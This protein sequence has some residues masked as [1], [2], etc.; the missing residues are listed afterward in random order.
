MHGHGPH[1]WW[2]AA[3]LVAL[4]GCSDAA[5]EEATQATPPAP[6]PLSP[7]AD[8]HAVAFPDGRGGT[9]CVPLGARAP[10]TDA[11]WP[12]V[13][14]D[15]L[16]VA[17]LGSP[18][19]TGTMSCPIPD[20]AAAIERAP[21]GGRVVLGSGV[22][23]L[24]GAVNLA[25]A[26]QLIGV[27]ASGETVI[28]APAGA[29]AFRVQATATVSRL[30][31]RYAATPPAE[32][33]TA[34][35]FDVAR[36]AS[37]TLGDVRI[38][39]A[40]IGAQCEGGA[41]TVFDA[42]VTGSGAFGVRLGPG[43]VARLERVVVRDGQGVG[44]SAFEAH[45]QF[46]NGLVERNGSTGV[47]LVGASDPTTGAAACEDLA[48]PPGRGPR[49]CLVRVASRGNANVAFSILG[50]EGPGATGTR[51]VTLRRVVGADTRV[52]ASGRGGV[53]LF[54]GD[55]A[56]VLVDDDTPEVPPQRHTTGE[57]S[58]FESNQGVGV[59]ANGAGT[60]LSLRGAL[61]ASNRGPGL[62]AQAEARVPEIKYARVHGNLGIGIG[63]T[64]AQVRSIT[65]NGIDATRM[66]TLQFVSESGLVPFQ[67]GDGLSLDSGLAELA[68]LV[69]QLDANARFPV[70]VSGGTGEVRGNYGSRNG[71]NDVGRRET[72]VTVEG[73][74]FVGGAAPPSSFA[75]ARGAVAP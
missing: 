66:H 75:V 64:G 25:R 12:R 19:C 46:V 21:A 60:S 55:G 59:L 41:L 43:C 4:V 70:V 40:D 68:V 53:G 18:V 37:L 51:A 56:S 27:G 6:L 73:N 62:F 65:C 9:E 17:P 30:T 45:L 48:T 24:R 8:P 31:V 33:R 63:A 50:P 52:T 44:V 10:R 36:G 20:L 35:A 16:W 15:A 1:V 26:V 71:F 22:H 11:E 57:R 3:A 54:V 2:S 14:G 7:C 32:R 38:V 23:V 28:E 34:V 69:N 42:T 5:P 47:S 72:R 29:A 13:E 67:V 74:R 39:Q 61:V 49:D 58:R